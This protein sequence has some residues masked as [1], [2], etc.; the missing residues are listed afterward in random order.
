[1]STRQKSS[2]GVELGKVLKKYRK[3]HGETQ[4]QLAER[5][6]RTRNTIAEYE[7]GAAVIPPPLRE[8]IAD[9]YDV[10]RAAL[11]L[12]LPR[13]EKN[14]FPEASDLALKVL[15]CSNDEELRS[16]AV[17]VLRKLIGT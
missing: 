5:L 8:K 9:C 7:R 10:P 16:L 2:E 14:R 3:L 12:D 1:M 11:G 17:T 6:G 4:L 15:E 13:V